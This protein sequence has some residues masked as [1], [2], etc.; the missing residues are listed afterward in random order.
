MKFNEYLLLLLFVKTM[1][2]VEKFVEIWNSF[3]MKT[4][5]ELSSS[6]YC[7]KNNPVLIGGSYLAISNLAF[8]CPVS[9][10]QSIEKILYF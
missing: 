3:L 8:C 5:G 10:M 9:S 4:C 6:C 2:L 7:V 1:E